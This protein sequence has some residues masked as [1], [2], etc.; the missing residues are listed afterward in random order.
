MLTF[1]H[2]S[3]YNEMLLVACSRRKN[4]TIL[5]EPVTFL[6]FN[7]Q[8]PTLNLGHYDRLV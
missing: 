1:F 4:L 8:M 2:S 6:N 3:L 5:A 7:W